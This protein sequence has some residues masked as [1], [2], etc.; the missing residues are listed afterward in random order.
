MSLT[1]VFEVFEIFELSLQEAFAVSPLVRSLDG[2]LLS[3]LLLKLTSDNMDRIM[4]GTPRCSFLNKGAQAGRQ[5][6]TRELQGSMTDHI[7]QYTV[8]AVS[9]PQVSISLA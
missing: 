1:L 8:V 7:V 2:V 3:L 4:V 6:A 9:Q 5:A